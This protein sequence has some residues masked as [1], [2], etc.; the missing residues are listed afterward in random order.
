MRIKLIFKMDVLPIAKGLGMLSLIKEMVREGSSE[1]Y[2]WLFI[3]NKMNM[4]PFSYS[5]FIQNLTIVDDE[6]LGTELHVTISSNSYEFMMHLANGS[7]KKKTYSIGKYKV[8][9]KRKVLLHKKNITKQNVIFKTLSPIL[10]ENKDRKPLLTTDKEFSNE[11]QYIAHLIIKEIYQREP[12]Q[13]IQVLQTMMTKQVL[14]ENLHQDQD[15]SLF[16]TVNK[17]LLH[18]HGHPNDLQ[19]LYDTGISLRRSLGLGLLELV[20][21]VE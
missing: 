10:I 20:K 4:K 15:K 6:I 3:K 19:A 21:E 1:Y 13:P 11:F 2:D 17:G 5:T 9:L 16:L 12:K 18:L 14:K 8:T 7:Q